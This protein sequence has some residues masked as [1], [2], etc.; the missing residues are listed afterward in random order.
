MN[1]NTVAI[2][3]LLVVALGACS[4]AGNGAAADPQLARQI[5][6]DMTA[7]S[8]R[9]LLGEPGNIQALKVGGEHVSDTWTYGEGA[10]LVTVVMVG[11]KVSAAYTGK[12]NTPVFP[13]PEEALDDGSDE[14]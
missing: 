14:G 4:P 12:A 10:Q 3:V 7:D 2:A 1:F 5:T 6:H 13:E 8:V 11:G 9:A